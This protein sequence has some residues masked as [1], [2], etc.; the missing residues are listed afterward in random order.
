MKERHNNLIIKKKTG[1][2]RRGC[3]KATVPAPFISENT[4][5]S[6]NIKRYFP[7]SKLITSTA[8]HMNKHHKNLKPFTTKS[9][10]N[11]IKLNLRDPF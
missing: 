11:P 3:I 5:K 1:K 6:Y 9:M 4:A 7:P 10:N 2:D 8:L